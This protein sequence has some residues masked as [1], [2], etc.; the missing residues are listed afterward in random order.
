[1]ADHV[2]IE[3]RWLQ[4]CAALFRDLPAY[5]VAVRCPLPILEQRERTRA[6]R[7]PG[8]ARAQLDRVHA[9]GA[10]DLEVDTGRLSPIDCALQIKERLDSSSPPTAL[11]RIARG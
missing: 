4:E 2:L 6:N 1:M 3:P 9:H 11:C 7:T 8:Q 5:L 10:Y